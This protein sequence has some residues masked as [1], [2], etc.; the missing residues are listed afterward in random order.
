MSMRFI[1]INLLITGILFL[2]INLPIGNRYLTESLIA[3]GLSSANSMS[4][5]FLAVKGMGREHTSFIKTVFG[6]MVIRLMVLIVLTVLVITMKWAEALP[7]FLMLMGF[8][9]IH[10]VIEILSL[11]RDISRKY[12][13]SGVK[14]DQ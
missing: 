1:I 10:Q 6:G 14:N 2:L 13:L 12:K 9:I 7:F 5:Y 4:G 3:A 8:Y 11:N